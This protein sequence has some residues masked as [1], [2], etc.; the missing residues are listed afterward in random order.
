MIDELVGAIRNALER[1]FSLDQ[2]MQ[3]LVNAG[4][5]P[6]E[7]REA[8]KYFSQSFLASSSSSFSVLQPKSVPQQQAQPAQPVQQTQRTRPTKQIQ[9]IKQTI[10]PSKLQIK[11]LP[12]QQ[13]PQAQPVPFKPIIVQP[14]QQIPQAQP[15]QPVR[16]MQPTIQIQQIQPVQQVPIKQ[17]KEQDTKQT[18][19]ILLFI[20]IFILGILML[21]IMFKDELLNLLF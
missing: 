6:I 3:S 10:M 11:P 15:V 16:Q 1:G 12:T 19:V 2:A 8:A 21:I 7:V 9:Q 18:I 14:I 20:L 13:I 5:N 4:Y 17:N